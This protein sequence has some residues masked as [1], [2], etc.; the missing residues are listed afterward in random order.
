MLLLNSG[1]LT[2][3]IIKTRCNG[4]RANPNLRLRGVFPAIRLQSGKS[5]AHPKLALRCRRSRPPSED[6]L[7]PSKSTESF[8][9]GQ[10][11]GLERQTSP[12][13]RYWMNGC[14]PWSHGRAQLGCAH[15]EPS[16]SALGQE[17]Q[18]D[19]DRWT[20]IVKKIRYSAQLRKL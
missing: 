15:L 10:M 6:R 3:G 9:D 8:C 14:L 17:G 11:A 4:S 2:H 7:P 1:T 5:L 18:D 12:W 19:L 20:E 16:L 13:R